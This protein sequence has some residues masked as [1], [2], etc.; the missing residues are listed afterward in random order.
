MF[1]IYVGP[2][3]GYI[4][5]DGVIQ[6]QRISWDKTFSLYGSGTNLYFGPIAAF[7]WTCLIIGALPYFRRKFFDSFYFLHIQFFFMA[8]IATVFHARGQVVPWLA[9]SLL[10]FYIDA[11]I[12]LMAKLSTVTPVSMEVIGDNITK[13]VF[14]VEGFPRPTF[15][16]HPGSYIWLSCNLRK[17]DPPATN[18][19]DRNYQTVKP[20]EETGLE[21]ADTIKPAVALDASTTTID[22]S[23]V[24]CNV[25]VAGGPP[26]GEDYECVQYHI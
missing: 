13:L 23:D 17:R 8:N 19:Q 7:F 15:K 14:K 10:P 20:N 21:L 9:A 24:F 3:G 2:D 16:Y 6:T 22:V 12:R 11:T 18:A 1:G 5:H 26:S 4:E 25:K